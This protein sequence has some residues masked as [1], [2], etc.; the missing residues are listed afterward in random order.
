MPVLTNY[1]NMQANF[2]GI[3]GAM[4]GAAQAGQQRQI[5]QG[6]FDAP[7]IG[8]QNLGRA[9]AAMGEDVG[10]IAGKMFRA[11]N[12]MAVSAADNMMREEYAKHKMEMATK[13]PEQWAEKWQ[14]RLPKL[15]DRISA[16]GLSPMAAEEVGMQFQKFTSSASI[17]LA[18][19]ALSETLKRGRQEIDNSVQRAVDEGRYEDAFSGV[20]KEIDSGMISPQEGEGMMIKIER[21]KREADTTMAMNADPEGFIAAVES[22]DIE[23]SPVEK[24]RLIR[25][26][27][28]VQREKMVES[29]D[30]LEQRVLTGDVKTEDE[31]RQ[32]GE[33]NGW[34]EKLV[35]SHIK[36]LSVIEE[37]SEAGQ[38][39][40]QQSRVD[41][42]AA[43]SA[44][45][46][47]VDAND[48][49]YWRIKDMINDTMPEGMRAEFLKDLSDDRKDGKIKP[50]KE[51]LSKVD[52]YT[53]LLLNANFFGKR[54]KAADK[55]AAAQRANGLMTRFRAWLK[56][57]PDT[58]SQADADDW[59]SKEVNGDVKK[60]VAEGFIQPKPTNV[61]VRPATMGMPMSGFT[62]D[63]N[64]AADLLEV[65]TE[66]KIK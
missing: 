23:V 10:Q 42:Q 48:K 3:Q 41:I 56:E 18:G 66:I 16:M 4:A 49:E 46:P 40:I 12:L 39:R 57:Q 61:G 60:S 51:I 33:E 2:G 28:I 44:Y 9:A 24:D 1:P 21:E 15:Q 26:A 5:G 65:E 20:M 34:P 63:K 45:N 52:S 6:A 55:L 31:I 58:V 7:A 14:A 13:P 59:I 19:D 36:T 47:E 62:T 30:A 22:G 27:K 53:S 38:A 50:K 64:S 25:N 17:D 37:G 35:L 54:D 8:M 11:Q 29:S 32:F 43:I